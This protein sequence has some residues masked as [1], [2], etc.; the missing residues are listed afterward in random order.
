MDDHFVDIEETQPPEVQDVETQVLKSEVVGLY[1][2]KKERDWVNR[3]L[4]KRTRRSSLETARDRETLQKLRNLFSIVDWEN[5]VYNDNDDTFMYD[6]LVDKRRQCLESAILKIDWENAVEWDRNEIDIRYASFDDDDDELYQLVRPDISYA[7]EFDVED[8]YEEDIFEVENDEVNRVQPEND[9]S[10]GGAGGADVVAGTSSS[11]ASQSAQKE[12]EKKVPM[13]KTE[14]DYQ[15]LVEKAERLAKVNI[16]GTGNEDVALTIKRMAEGKKAAIQEKGGTGIGRSFATVLEHTKFATKHKM[17]KPDLLPVE[18][19]NF[20]RPRLVTKMQQ[21]PWQIVFNKP[22]KKQN[23][24]FRMKGGDSIENISVVDGDFMVMEYI[25][26]YPPIIMNPGMASK[27][28]NYHRESGEDGQAGKMRKV[29]DTYKKIEE[30]GQY[31]PRHVRA[32][33]EKE[34]REMDGHTKSADTAFHLPVGK[35][36][37]LSEK[38]RFPFMGQLEKEETQQTLATNAFA[39]P[40][41]AQDLIN[42]DFLLIR[43]K[44][45]P[46]ITFTIRPIDTVF[47]CGQMEPAQKVLKPTQRTTLIK[48]Q[49]DFITLHIVRKFHQHFEENLHA[50]GVRFST[51]K[52]MFKVSNRFKP[53][54]ADTNLKKIMRQFALE[55]SDQWY[56]KD[57]TIDNRVT[58]ALE[59]A[60]KMKRFSLEELETNFDPEFVCLQES[61]NANEARLLEIGIRNIDLS[62]LE[63][64]LKRM[65]KIKATYVNRYKYFKRII[66][67]NNTKMTTDSRKKLLQYSILM[68]RRTKMLESKVERA[69]FIFACLAVAS[70]N[71][72][73]AFIDSLGH[74]KLEL[75]NKIVDPSGG[76]HEAFAF[77]RRDRVTSSS[78]RPKVKMI[79]STDRDLR[80]MR[81]PELKGRLIDMGVSQASLDFLNRWDMVHLVKEL[82]SKAV[83]DD[84]A[85]DMQ[86]FARKAK[87]TG[88]MK[89]ED[90]IKQAADIWKTQVNAL[91]SK[92]KHTSELDSDSSSE[93]DLD[94]DDFDNDDGEE[95][96]SMF[97]GERTSEAAELSALKDLTAA[98][99]IDFPDGGSS[100]SHTGGDKGVN[101]ARSLEDILGP[102]WVRPTKVVKKIERYIRSDGQECLR[103]KFILTSSEVARVERENIKNK[104]GKYGVLPQVGSTRSELV[105][106][107]SRADSISDQN[108]VPG[109]AASAVSHN[110]LSNSNRNLRQKASVHSSFQTSSKPTGLQSYKFELN[111]RLEKMLMEVFAWASAGDFRHPVPQAVP[112]YYNIIDHPISLTD[113]RNKLHEL[114]YTTL[115]TF[116]SDIRLM[117]SNAAKFNG[118]HSQLGINAY[119]IVRHLQ[120]QIDHDNTHQ[121]HDLL[122]NLEANIGASEMADA[123]AM[124]EKTHVSDSAD[125]TDDNND[126]VVDNNIVVDEDDLFGSDSDSSDSGEEEVME[127]SHTFST[128]NMQYESPLMD[129]SQPENATGAVDNDTVAAAGD[130]EGDDCGDDDGFEI[131]EVEEQAEVDKGEDMQ[132]TEDMLGDDSDDD[133][134]YVQ[135][136]DI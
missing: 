89:Y 86:K 111:A 124:N 44:I 90:Y 121:L 63:L 92:L 29:Q 40:V 136:M 105:R 48:E 30:K 15:Q 53:S 58:S 12:K 26:E 129:D 6:N 127:S 27:V 117:A 65:V 7:E 110:L 87:V 123:A 2:K 133:I 109:S 135:K 85:D 9:E 19:R 71:T 45:H 120:D 96:Y 130:D 70:W 16:T 4:A 61:C 83:K 107:R 49:E 69:R 33:M 131:E 132:I 113:I 84:V 3:R 126:A 50:G 24:R 81:M 128:G 82:A 68:N 76:R 103:V 79:E 8:F 74:P 125:K 106:G 60:E 77:I 37:V 118:A 91:K 52:D 13:T 41:F 88:F 94:L 32:L 115:A 93:S 25:E 36:E 11:G 59:Q 23:S 5:D 55:V 14:R 31:L 116:M 64:W 54:H 67:Y 38:D 34:S 99:S 80:K 56:L 62:K 101:G 42:N 108:V 95:D 22:Q 17:C 51:I 75:E 66:G 100:S 98:P 122:G 102:N 21:R 134:Q 112:N 46:I 20:H 114:H 73:D 28:I 78:K 10:V 119:N 72:T 18:L 57:F 35:L 1:I 47:L 43:T 39:A 104:T 97:T